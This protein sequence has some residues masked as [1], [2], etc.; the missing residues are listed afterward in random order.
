MKESEIKKIP[1][2]DSAL[3]LSGNKLLH[4]VSFPLAIPVS[5]A[6]KLQL[7]KVTNEDLRFDAEACG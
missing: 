2:T 7:G 4:V 1:S 6:H 5:Y 3:L